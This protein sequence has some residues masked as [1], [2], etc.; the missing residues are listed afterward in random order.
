MGKKYRPYL[1]MALMLI[2]APFADTAVASGRCGDFVPFE[3]PVA[4][5]DLKKHTVYEEPALGASV[6]YQGP[7]GKLTYYQYDL[8]LDHISD[9]VVNESVT[10]AVEDIQT[11]IAM[12]DGKIETIMSSGQEHTVADVAFADTVVVSTAADGQ[13][14]DFVAVGTDRRCLHKVRYTPDVATNDGEG[15]NSEGLVVY[16]RFVRALDGLE[17]YL[18]E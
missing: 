3:G 9:G 6:T 17:P 1:V 10:Y 8:G 18:S 14:V 2:A 11:V 12:L 5:M 15:R 4:D 7:D 13:K 16:D